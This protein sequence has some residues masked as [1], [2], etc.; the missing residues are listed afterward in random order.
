MGLSSRRRFL[1]YAGLLGAGAA[2]A[3][4]GL[5]NF[6]RGSS[7]QKTV[8]S[9]YSPP[10]NAT[11][12]YKEFMT[13]LA[14][15]S[16]PYAGQTVNISL[17]DEST[18]RALQNLDLDFLNATG[19][20]DSYDL[21]PYFLHLTDITL[22]ANEK[23]PTYDV[24]SV[25]NQDMAY[26]KD[27]IISPT[28]LAEKYPDLTYEKFSASDFQPIAWS[29]LAQYPQGPYSSPG[30]SGDV[31]FIPLDMTTMLQYYR[32][33]LFSAS[34]MTPATTWDQ[35]VSNAKALTD[36][37]NRSNPYGTVNETTPDISVVY[38]FLNF[39]ASYG[40]KL[41]NFDG[42]QL[43]S[44]LQSDSALSALET[45]I[46]LKPFSDPSS[47]TYS[48]SDVTA[49][50]ERGVAAEGMLW[51]DFAHFMD[52]G[53]RSLVVG[54]MQYAPNPAGPAG[55]FSTY[56]GNGIGVS[57]FSQSPQAAWLWLQWASARG[58]QEAMA[59]GPLQP[60]PS[61][62]GVIDEPAV[63]DAIGGDAYRS[64]RVIKQIWDAEQI[65]S[66]IAFPKWFQ[67]LD[68]IAAHLNNAWL[69]EETPSVAMV[70]AVQKIETLGSLTFD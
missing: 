55:S 11:P 20:N 41:W 44:A 70:N 10:A 59:L 9:S 22:M 28:Q 13:W 39:L 68:P 31:L 56:A 17:E 46:S 62:V 58:T 57:R 29:L 19:I 65:A 38:E 50:L 61:R 54:N 51:G 6:D 15:V 5:M 21:K 2:L 3:Y 53:T 49:D 52:D 69:R 27:D 35:Y 40:G 32:K 16:K 47:Y 12:D 37:A 1:A 30:A 4:F 45:Y 48:W 36:F 63:R 24:F 34:S 23:A 26:F 8:G 18:P 33:D 14:S 42:T 67:A 25:D 60:F 64:L 66:F 7:G 43:T